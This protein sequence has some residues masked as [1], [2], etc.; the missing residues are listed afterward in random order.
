MFDKQILFYS[1]FCKHSKNF[2]HTLSQNSKL[3]EDFIRINIDVDPQT[4][5]RPRLFYDIQNALQYKIEEVPTIIVNKA[6][7]VLS[8]KD[9]F[10]WLEDQM[11]PVVQMEK[12][13]SAFNPIEMGGFS[14][15]YAMCGS[16]SL[17]DNS[18]EQCFKFL[19][20]SDEPI[21]TPIEE[22]LTSSTGVKVR[23]SFTNSSG[24]K[25]NYNFNQ[26]KSGISQKQ[27]DF[28]DRYQQLLSER[29]QLNTVKPRV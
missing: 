11:Q 25:N 29:E 12:E 19:G 18:A 21:Q 15:T 20:K 27:K 5:S 6:E 13:V 26:L 2:I 28:D 24:K 22:A 8:G 23:E 16:K 9:A 1:N 10:Q 7:Y 17:H 3:Y 14:D 4:R